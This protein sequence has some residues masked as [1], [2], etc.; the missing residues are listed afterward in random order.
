MGRKTKGRKIYKTKEKNYY[1]KTP[2]GK[3]FSVALSVLLIGGLG[4]IGYSVAEPIVKYTKKKGDD[5][6]NVADTSDPSERNGSGSD[7]SETAVYKAYALKATDLKNID[8]LNAALD[9]IPAV[10]G[11]EF[12]EVPLKVSGGNIYYKSGVQL[13]SDCHAVQGS[14]VLSDI[15]TAIDDAGYK[16]AGLV[17]AFNDSLLPKLDKNT[18]YLVKTGEQ[19]IDNTQEAGG[20]PW[21]T[22]YSSTSVNYI[23]DIVTEIASAGFKKIICSDISY[24]DFR[25]VDLDYLPDELANKKRFQVLTSAANLFYDRAVN[26]G[27]SLSVE[28]SG[29]DILKGNTD[30]IDEPLYLNVKSLVVNINIDEI[31]KGVHTDSTVYEF[32]G[33]AA[34]KTAKFLELTKD[35][36]KDYDKAVIRLTGT[37]VG[38]DELLKA[39]EVITDYGYESF[40]IG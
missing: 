34:D 6:V 28:I 5:T 18:G 25:K 35:K 36:L 8:A 3:A 37:S 2:L 32:T 17:S 40:I 22:P 39:K 24:P 13:A 29:T 30:L 23:G 19:W 7:D 21:L 33:T 9:R 27:S 4:F 10:T 26:Y 15:V 12:V 1:G 16:P 31:S 14:L 38:V 20:R 11:I